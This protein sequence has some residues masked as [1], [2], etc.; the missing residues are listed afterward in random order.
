[1]MPTRFE[2][3]KTI[4]Q[5]GVTAVVDLITKSGYAS[6]D[7]C[8]SQRC[9]ETNPEAIERARRARAIDT[10]DRMRAR[11]RAN[12]AL[13]AIMLSQ[14]IDALRAALRRFDGG[15]GDGLS[16]QVVH[17]LRLIDGPT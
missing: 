10:A 13:R 3:I 15:G 9:G 17:L 11:D 5:Q 16:L 14:D 6:D 1:M 7:C 2:N 8:M 4:A 12:L